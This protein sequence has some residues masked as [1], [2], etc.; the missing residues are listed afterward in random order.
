MRKSRK[1]G[2][3]S[4]EN[5]ALLAGNVSVSVDGD[6][7]RIV[8]D[9]QGNGVSV[10]QL[11]TNKFFVTG[12]GLNGSN[13][14]I[15]G[16]LAGRVVSGVRNIDADLNAGY[17]IFVMSNSAWRR[18]DLAQ[19]LSGGTAGPIQASPQAANPNTTNSVTTRVAG[20]VT[21]NTDEGNDGVG[22]GARIG[23]RDSNGNIVDGVLTIN[24]ANGADR[25]IVERTEAFD[26]M[27]FDM[28]SGNDRVDANTVRVGDFLFASLGDGAD[29]FNSNNAHGWHSQI[30]GGNHNDVVDVRNFRMEQEVFVD[31]G[32]GNDRI[33]GAGVGGISISFVTGDGADRIGVDGANSRG[34]A[35]VDTGSGDDFVRLNGVF[36]ADHAGV[37][38]GDGDDTLRVKDSTADSATLNGGAGFDRFFNDGGN[39]LGSVDISDYEN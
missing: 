26:D 28:G 35:T 10:E 34:G 16:Q 39:N 3:E 8:G 36:V 37:F 30:L 23:T 27:L 7:L 13:T 4:L 29:R 21:I 32:S 19:Q 33:Y 20:D 31:T 22:I 15:N 17:D 9:G 14:T 6:V 38:Q 5:R 11:D 1:L 18:N 25:A 2:V 24:G 12:F